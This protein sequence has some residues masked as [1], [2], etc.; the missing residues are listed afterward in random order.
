MLHG[1]NS[2][3]AETEALAGLA[4]GTFDGSAEAFQR[5][6]HPDDWPAYDREMQASV[7]ERRDSLVSF[8]MIWPDGSVRWIEGRGPRAVCPRRQFAARDRHDHGRHRAQTGGGGAARQRGALPQT[9]QGLP[10]PTY[11]WLQVGDD[12]V[13]QD[14]NDAADAI[15]DGKI[16][17]GMSASSPR[18]GT[19]ISRT[20]WPIFTTLRDRA[21]HVPAGDAV[22]L[23]H[24]RAACES[25]RSATSSCRR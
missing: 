21:A 16:R 18:S 24:R 8:R 11:S 4:R 17:D 12:F 5:L 14:F 2:W 3:S 9:V 1:V 7:A 10:L 13:L 22:P 25:W 23:P 15:S 19:R 20:S 6:V